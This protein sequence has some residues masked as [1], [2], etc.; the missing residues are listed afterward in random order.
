VR[1]HPAGLRGSLVGR[2]IRL[3][4]A[5]RTAARVETVVPKHDRHAA[6]L[7]LQDDQTQLGER[8]LM[9]PGGR[10]ARAGLQ[11]VVKPEQR[12]DHTTEQARP[13]QV[14]AEQVSP[15][16]ANERAGQDLVSREP[17]VLPAAVWRAGGGHGP[18]SSDPISGAGNPTGAT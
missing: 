17:A 9:R 8:G 11:R 18:D 10:G 4:A 5:R 2:R 14:R 13:E 15:E 1:I 12:T 7:R 16:P 3:R 6:R